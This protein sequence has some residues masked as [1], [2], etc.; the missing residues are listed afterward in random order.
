MAPDGHID[1]KITFASAEPLDGTPLRDEDLKGFL[2]DGVEVAADGSRCEGAFGGS[3]VTESDGL[4]LEARYDCPAGATLIEVTLYYLNTLG[5]GHR[6]VAR[7]VAAGNSAEGLLTGDRRALSLQLPTAPRPRA[8]NGRRLIVLT[9]S[10]LAFML[11]LFVW[12][13][14]ATRK[15]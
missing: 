14:R 13:W 8:R 5:R 1:G 4:L 7:I 12:R 10:F 11:G 6:E 9:A 3:S 2:M 15:R